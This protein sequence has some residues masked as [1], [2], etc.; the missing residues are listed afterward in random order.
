[1]TF[2]ADCMLGKLARWLRIL[3]YDTVYDNFAADDDLL[4]VAGQEGRVLLT[5][6]RPLVERAAAMDDV[7]CI[8]ID[9]LDIDDQVAQMVADASIDLDRP[10]FTRCLE[11]NVGIDSVSRDEVEAVVPPYVLQTRDTFYWCPSCERVYW[12]G[13][14][15]SRM[16]ARIDAFREAVSRGKAAQNV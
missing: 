16:N 6:D 15:T 9:A 14:H 10:T 1:M 13:S 5:R 4:R 2:L 3:G 8:H 12:S 7:T 11:C